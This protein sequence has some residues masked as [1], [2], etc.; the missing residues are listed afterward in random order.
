MSVIYSWNSVL[1]TLCL[2]GSPRADYCILFS[3][4]TCYR[5]VTSIIHML[6]IC[7]HIV[8]MLY[9]PFYLIQEIDRLKY[10]QPTLH[11]RYFI[12]AMSIP[13]S[14]STGFWSLSR[15]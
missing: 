13:F 8:Y 1:L 3:H 15:F 9:N 5:P 11:P 12:R 4:M 14:L 2:R 6:F 7:S 10:L